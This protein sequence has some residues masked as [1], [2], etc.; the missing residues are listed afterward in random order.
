MTL[1]LSLAHDAIIAELAGT[2][3][4]SVFTELC[5][6]IARS[7]GVPVDALVA[8]LLE[9]EQLASTAVGH[10]VAMPHGVH[11]GL[12]RVVACFGR[13]RVGLQFGAPDGVPVRLFV[14]LVRPPDAASTHLKALAKW[15]QLLASDEVRGALL[16][17]P[18]ADDIRRVL[19]ERGK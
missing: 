18:T 10:G 1:P 13:S 12:Q 19:D 14:A 9:R 6:P 3:T 15:S 4:E 8:A 16:V 7:E 17:A 5:A 2:D 11:P